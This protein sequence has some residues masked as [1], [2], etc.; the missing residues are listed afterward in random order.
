[1]LRF[2]LV[3]ALLAESAAAGALP[4]TRAAQ[5]EHLVRQDCGACHGMTLAGGLGPDIRPAALSAR[6]EAAL[7][8]VILDGR[9]GTAMPPWRPLLNEEE[10]AWI[11]RYLMTGDT[12]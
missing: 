3:L 5:L 10:A 7:V 12:P 8:S 6:D 9:P 1:M 2:T 11:A 4:G